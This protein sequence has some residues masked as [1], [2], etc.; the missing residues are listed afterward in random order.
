MPS[1]IAH[2]LPEAVVKP[3]G[4]QN[5]GS[6]LV[7]IGQDIGSVELNITREKENNAPLSFA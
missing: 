7:A 6:L 5:L 4:T 2:N 3:I 1:L